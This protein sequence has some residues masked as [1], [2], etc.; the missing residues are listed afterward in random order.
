MAASRASETIAGPATAVQFSIPLPHSPDTRVYIHLTSQAK[1]TVVFL[2]TAAADELGTLTPMGSLVYALPDVRA[3]FW[4]GVGFHMLTCLQK[5]NPTQPL[6]TP[7]VVVEPT[8]DFTARFA[9]LLAKRTGLPV[10]VAN[11]V[12]LAS[13]G[14]GGVVDEEMEAFQTVVKAVLARLAHLTQTLKDVPGG[15]DDV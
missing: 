6:S 9:R 5:R 14:L 4:P 12:S 11:S 15:I 1:A 10:Y 13:V 3:G 7:L 2:T 8:L